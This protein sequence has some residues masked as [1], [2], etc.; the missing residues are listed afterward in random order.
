VRALPSLAGGVVGLVLLQPPIAESA[1]RLLLPSTTGCWDPNSVLRRNKPE[2]P[3]GLL[4]LV[5]SFPCIYTRQSTPSSPHL[6][7]LSRASRERE[8]EDK[9]EE[10]RRT[11]ISPTA[12]L[13]ASGV[14]C[15]SH[16]I[17][18]WVFM[19]SRGGSGG[20]SRTNCSSDRG[21]HRRAAL[22]REQEVSG[23]NSW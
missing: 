2:S 7:S 6:L 1:A 9:K 23:L 3:G 17:V 5:L 20:G 12:L 16:R 8:R 4:G 14:V 18:L 15:R 22:H 13:L 19:F 11:L 21:H 10:S